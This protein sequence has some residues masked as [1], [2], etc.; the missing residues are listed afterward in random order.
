VSLETQAGCQTPAAG[1]PCQVPSALSRPSNPK[2]LYLYARS[3]VAIFFHPTDQETPDTRCF[4]IYHI[5]S[6]AELNV[7]GCVSPF[8]GGLN[9]APGGYRISDNIVPNSFCLK[10]IRQVIIGSGTDGNYNL[11]NRCQY[12]FLSLY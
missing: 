6:K 4:L 3:P 1:V 5:L 11:I 2:R 7:P 9:Y 12:L 8:F 10:H